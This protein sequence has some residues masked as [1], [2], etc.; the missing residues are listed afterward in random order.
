MR[1]HYV[2]YDGKP[3]SR[4]GDLP[5]SR[6][7]AA[8][9]RL[10]DPGDVLP[11]DAPALIG[12]LDEDGAPVAFDT[13][14]DRGALLGVFHRVVQKV[15]NGLGNA[16]AVHPDQRKRWRDF[17]LDSQTSLRGQGLE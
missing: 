16:V 9:G 14:P 2:L 15:K 12:H 17:R 10:E 8:I 3:Q 7:A 11:A 1:L 6:V 5:V 13:H 4:A